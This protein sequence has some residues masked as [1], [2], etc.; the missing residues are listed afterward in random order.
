MAF[1]LTTV[2]PF[3]RPVLLYRHLGSSVRHANVFGYR[4]SRSHPPVPLSDLWP[5]GAR[6]SAPA[7]K[8][9]RVATQRSA[10]RLPQHSARC[11][12]FWLDAPRPRG[13]DPQGRTPPHNSG[14]RLGGLGPCPLPTLCLRSAPGWPVVSLPASP[15]PSAPLSPPTRPTTLQPPFA[16]GLGTVPLPSLWVVLVLGVARVFVGAIAD[17]L[18][19]G[20]NRGSRLGGF[21]P[22]P[23]PAPTRGAPEE[24]QQEQQQEQEH[25]Q[26]HYQEQ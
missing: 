12:L 23:W 7:A 3:H 4:L 20:N 6:P 26:E 8:T 15:P 19:R 2:S 10:A 17:P 22:G 24:Q 13:A 14:S 1:L 21:G 5:L 11:P 25:Y 16:A 18:P 9:L